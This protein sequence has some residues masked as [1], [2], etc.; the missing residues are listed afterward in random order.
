MLGAEERYWRL[1]PKVNVLSSQ[2]KIPQRSQILRGL[3]VVIVLLGL[4]LLWN[5]RSTRTEVDESLLTKTGELRSLQRELTSK[6]QG[7]DALRTRINE[8][9]GQQAS[10]EQ[11]FRLI[12]LNNIDWYAALTSLFEAQTRGITF[13]SVTAGPGGQVLLRGA[14]TDEGSMSSL[15]SQLATIETLEF[16][17]IRWE[18]G[19]DPPAFSAT[20]RVRQ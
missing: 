14:A 10:S 20:F 9:K 19:S 8:L 1:V 16:Q 2:R 11:A 3:L 13:G 17:S 5:Q 18:P 7:F 12:T 15:P 6:Q 4:F